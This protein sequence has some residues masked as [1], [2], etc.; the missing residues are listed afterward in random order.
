M[1]N[2]Y[3]AFPP[4]WNNIRVPVHSK[5]ATLAG[6]A[7]YTPCLAK[8]IWGQRVA[9]A[10]VALGGARLLPGR[11]RNWEPPLQADDW[12][13]L[14][15]SLEAMVATVRETGEAPTA[16]PKK[17]ALRPRTAPPTRT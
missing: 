14:L 4:G 3:K 13:D 5:G 17:K 10:A 2:R 9:W 7:T 8:G 1:K 11:A 16:A 6:I 15:E 12:S